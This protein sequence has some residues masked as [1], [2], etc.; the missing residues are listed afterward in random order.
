MVMFLGPA[1]GALLISLWWMFFSRLTWL[2]RLLIP[3]AYALYGLGMYL[4]SDSSIGVFGLFLYGLPTAMTAW[5]L[6]L[7]VSYPLPWPARRAGL[8]VGLVMAW[9]YFTLLR[10]DGV[11]GGLSANLNW[12]WSHTA[13]DRFKTELASLVIPDRPCAR[14]RPGQAARTSAWRLA[15]LSWREPRAIRN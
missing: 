3:V 13:E 9:G 1:I 5:V 15:Q 4:T 8:L 14:R 6:W 11:D 7:V 2:D 10:M 12:R